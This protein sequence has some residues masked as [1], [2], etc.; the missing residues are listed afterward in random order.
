MYL[1]KRV[2]FRFAV[3]GSLASVAFSPSLTTD[4][5]AS[6]QS[7][8][9]ETALVSVRFGGGSHY[10]GGR[11]YGGYRNH[12]WGGRYGGYHHYPS[13]RYHH[14]Y[15]WPNSSFYYYNR[16]YSP[17]Y[18]RGYYPYYGRNYYYYR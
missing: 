10:R 1:F 14:N 5:R 13:Y 2:L 9:K 4:L 17:Y 11:G 3:I 6:H 7:S 8:D 12:N 16:G 18:N 15:G